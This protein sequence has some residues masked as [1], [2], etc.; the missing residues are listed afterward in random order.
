MPE[1]SMQDRMQDE[2]IK[3]EIDEINN[4]CKDSLIIKCYIT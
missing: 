3:M 1:V 4:I 2:K